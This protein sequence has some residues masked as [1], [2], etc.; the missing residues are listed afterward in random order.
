MIKPFTLFVTIIILIAVALFFPQIMNAMHGM[1]VIEMLQQA[2]GF[3]LHVI[4]VSILAY[5]LYTANE[6]IQPW[7]KTLKQKQHH[8]RRAIRGRRIITP[9]KQAGAGTSRHG[10]DA[11]LLWLL[12]QL[13]RDHQEQKKRSLPAQSPSEQIHWD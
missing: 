7:I 5:A 1:S 2:V 6:L 9:T 11:S 4:V 8:Y 10:K 12:N 3:V 13:A